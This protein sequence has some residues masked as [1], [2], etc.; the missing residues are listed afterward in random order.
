MTTSLVNELKNTGG[1]MFARQVAK[2]GQNTVGI[3]CV[4]DANR[5]TAIESD[6]VQKV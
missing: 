2:C 3:N 5:K 4:K 1:R 6:Q